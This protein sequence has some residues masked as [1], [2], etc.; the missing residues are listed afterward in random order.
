MSARPTV[1]LDFGGTLVDTRELRPLLYGDAARQA[2][3]QV[4]MKEFFRFNDEVW[5]ELWPEATQH[6][7]KIP[8]FADLV[9]ER[10]LRLARAEGP[11]EAM[12]HGIRERALSSRWQPPFPEVEEVL[13]E[14]RARGH[15]LHVLSNNVDYLPGL[16]EDLGWSGFFD[17]VNF[18]QQVG[19]GTP[20]RHFFEFALRRAGCASTEL[21]HVGDSFEADYLGARGAGPRAVWVNRTELPVPEGALH[22]RDLGGLLP[23]IPTS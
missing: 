2:G 3:A 6:L 10:A 19:T 15:R 7:G 9:H 1:F 13:R 14:L 12:V 8:S 18:S 5:R 21:I 16:V 22:V 4:P 17:G 11:V 20:D 23:L